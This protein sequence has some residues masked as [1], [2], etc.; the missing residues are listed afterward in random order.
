MTKI[1]LYLL[2]LKPNP[3]IKI[4]PRKVK[5]TKWEGQRGSDA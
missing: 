5:R 1:M 2:L 4:K 3:H